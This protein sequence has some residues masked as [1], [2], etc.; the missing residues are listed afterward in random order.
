LD[1][2]WRPSLRKGIFVWDPTPAAAWIALEEFH[3][4]WIKHQHS[5]H[6]FVC[7]HVMMPEWRNQFHKASGVV[8]IVPVG[9]PA[10]PKAMF[11][12][13]LIG[14]IFPFIRCNPWQL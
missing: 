5:S 4:A 6:I 7:P 8:F 11:E 9:H 13:L 2:L 14:I 3:T 10:W 1:G 12:P